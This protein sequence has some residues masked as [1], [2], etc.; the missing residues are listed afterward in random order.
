MIVR[1]T[2][3]FGRLVRQA[4]RDGDLTQA[5]LAELVGVSRKWIIDI[6][7]GKK[8]LEFGLALRTLNALGIDLDGRPRH[9]RSPGLDLD[10]I[11]AAS[12]RSTR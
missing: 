2:R 1:T 6:E 4:R 11:V 9:E 3:D 7:A 10:A 5:R 12:R 8:T